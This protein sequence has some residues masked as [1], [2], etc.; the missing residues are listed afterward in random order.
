MAALC[1]ALLL[2]A[3]LG[4]TTASGA[5][6]VWSFKMGF[7]PA[8]LLL[9]EGLL[10]IFLFKN[11]KMQMVHGYGIVALAALAFSWYFMALRTL[12]DVQL[13]WGLFLPLPALVFAVLAIRAIRSD[14]RLVRSADRLR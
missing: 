10:S 8:I 13:S 1:G 12:G 4:V 7:L 3:P 2:L 6:T 9:A 14:E 5:Y 11:R